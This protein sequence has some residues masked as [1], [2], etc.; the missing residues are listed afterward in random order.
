MA[1]SKLLF[2][3][4]EKNEFQLIFSQMDIV[5]M[6]LFVIS[7]LHS[8]F[9]LL[10]HLALL[11]YCTKGTEKCVKAL[12]LVTARGLLSTAVAVS[13]ALPIVKWAVILGASAWILFKPV[14]KEESKA[15]INNIVIITVVFALTT[16]LA[17]VGISSYPITAIF[18]VISFTLPFLAIMVG[19]QS[20]IQTYKWSDYF[21]LMLL[22]LFAVSLVLIPFK[23]FR[24]INSDFQGVFNH[25]NMLGIMSPI[26]IAGILHS[27]FFR[28]RRFLRFIII[29]AVLVM[30][31]L[32]SSRTG[33]FSSVT[34]IL[35]YYLFG[36]QPIPKK[37]G[38]L[39]VT[40]SFVFVFYMVAQGSTLQA[41]EDLVADFIWKGHNTSI[42][43]SREGLIE[44]AKEKFNQ[45]P[46]FGS[47]FMVPYQSGIVDWGLSFDLMVEP[48]NMLWALL[49][50]T[51]AF[52]TS[53]FA[54]LFLV[55][56]FQGK[57]SNLFILIAAF[58]INFGE[59]VFFS[60]NN[61]SIFI[62]FL[63]ALYNFTPDR[64]TEDL[65]ENSDTITILEG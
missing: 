54:I 35:V 41:V 56:L 24:L 9:G 11:Y 28:K 46:W 3:E 15:K 12:L 10:F 59:M 64:N 38:I 55:I 6:V 21:A 65:N 50:D 4:K 16:A 5:F 18:K 53:I 63:I 40:L 22:P 30:V 23:Q 37:I 20:T 26:F 43:Y 34:V 39:C 25:V 42:F 31:Y 47:G 2:L 8:V 49:G 14:L 19:V 62:Y 27:E 51:G 58:M 60:S 17:S 33:M 57:R 52:G 1:K 13:P 45:N 44:L 61:M 36:N 29:T 48:G 32:S 7:C